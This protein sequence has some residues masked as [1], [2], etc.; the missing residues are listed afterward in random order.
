VNRTSSIQTKYLICHTLEDLLRTKPLSKITVIEI[1]EKSGVSRQTFYRHFEDIYALVLWLFDTTN[2]A[3][4]SFE[5]SKDFVSSIKLSLENMTKHPLLYRQIF[6]NDKDKLF[7][8]KLLQNRIE[9]CKEHY[10]HVYLNDSVLFAIEFFWN[11]YF[12]MLLRWIESGM[13]ETP[14]KLTELICSSLPETLK[15]LF[16]AEEK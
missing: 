14:E 3:V 16:L 7:V 4:S 15:F 12:C 8:K 1:V 11:G 5:K 9:F 2:D 13:K 10:G 6:L